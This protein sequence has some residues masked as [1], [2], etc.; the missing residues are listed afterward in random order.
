[1]VPSCSMRSAAFRATI[2]ATA[3][4]ALG[5]AAALLY[6][7][8]QQFTDLAASLRAFDQHA[9]EAGDALV[10]ARI[11]LQAYVAAGQGGDYWTVKVSSSTD[12]AQN[13]ITAL[14]EAASAPALTP[15]EQAAATTAEFAAVD[16]RVREYLKFGDT[17]MAADVIF[18]EGGENAAKAVRQ[19]ETARQAEHQTFDRTAAAM[20]KQEATIVGAAAAVAGLAVLL[21]APIVR[22]RAPAEAAPLPAASP[23]PAPVVASAPPPESSTATIRIAAS[24]ATDF[25]RVRDLDDLRS[26][27]G[28]TAHAMDASGLMVWMGSP[29]GNDLRVVLAHGYA[30]EVL[31]R[32][33][34]V[35]R[36]ADNAAAK[37][38]RSGTLQIVLSR[39]GGAH[40]AVVAPIVAADGCVGA[41]SAEIRHGAETSEGVQA[42]AEIAAAHLAGVLAQTPAEI[43]EPHAAQ[44]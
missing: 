4:I 8:E 16:K 32:I 25:G 41:L 26:L 2:G 31:A 6:R 12:A 39:P 14:R 21:L 13:A 15:L 7:S 20:R 11:G 1:M 18:T 3:W 44:A 42:L 36:S 28:K 19:L 27:L 40:G 23:A 34:P 37:A 10:E 29:Q 24:L 17:L 9:R 35:P 22:R 43:S 30:D 5:V 33:P 38:F